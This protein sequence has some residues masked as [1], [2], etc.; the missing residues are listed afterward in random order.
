MNSKFYIGR[1]LYGGER[2][3]N[4]VEALDNSKYIVILAEPGAGKTRLLES[5]AGRLNVQKNSANAFLHRPVTDRNVPVVIDGFDELAKI[6]SSGIHR[7]LG[8]ACELRPSKLVISSRS[9]EWD[10]SYTK[11]FDDYFECKPV[12]LRIYPFGQD[13]QQQLFENYLINESFADFKLQVSRFDLEPLLP[14]PQFLKL[15]ADAYIESNRN[16]INKKSI[17]SLAVDRLAKESNTSINAR[18]NLPLDKKVELTE[19]IFAK[20]LLSGA[21]GVNSSDV[22]AD[23]VFPYI[24]SLFT[25]EQNLE[26]LLSSKLFLFGE[27][28]NQHYPVHKIVMEYCAANYLVRKISAATSFLSLSQSLAII[29][30]N[31]VVRDELRGL[32][33]WMAALGNK[34]IQ[35][36]LVDLDPYAVLANGDPSQLL[37]SSKKRLLQ[38]LKKVADENPHF[39]RSDMW[40]TFSVAGFFTVDFIEDLRVVL[41]NEINEGHL[42]GLIL[43]LLENSQVISLLL[44][45]LEQF[46]IAEDVDKNIRLLAIQRLFECQNFD[47]KAILDILISN[48]T[49]TSL[50]IAEF[51]IE[52]VGESF[53]GEFYIRDFL[54]KCSHLYPAHNAKWKENLGERYFIRKIISR[55]DL[56]LTEFLLNNFSKDIQCI[57]GKEKYEC[58]C[59]T[60]ISKVVGLLLDRYFEVTKHPYSSLKI[61][62]WIRNL[63]FHKVKDDESSISVK[64]IQENDDLRQGII[65]QI[66]TEAVDEDSVDRACEIFF[67]SHNHSGLR[68]KSEDYFF[69]VDMAFELGNVV[70][71]SRFLPIHQ[72]YNN[73][74]Q[75]GSLRKYMKLQARNDRDFLWVWIKRNECNKNNFINNGKYRYS[76]LRRR[77]AR[78]VRQREKV[79]M[80]NLEF[81]KVNR[82]LIESG[83]H[84]SS[85]IDFSHLLLFNL[86]D[87]EDKYEYKQIARIALKNCLDFIEPYVPNLEELVRLQFESKSKASEQVLY[88]ACLEIYREKSSLN[89]IKTNILQS[90]RTNLHV[91]YDGVTDEERQALRNEVDRII[92]PTIQHAE[93]FLRNYIEPQLSVAGFG[94][95]EIDWLKYD[96]VFKPLQCSLSLEWLSKYPEISLNTADTLFDL[97]LQHGERDILE[98]IIL[99]RCDFY[100]NLLHKHKTLPDAFKEKAQFWFFRGFI[101]LCDV[102]AEA[103][104]N[105]LEMD[106][107]SIFLFSDNVDNL[108]YGASSIWPILSP[109]KVW[110]I[111]NGFI[112]KWPKVYL[113]S[114]WGTGDPENEI[115]YRFLT[116]IFWVLDKNISNDSISIL[117][118]LI[119]DNRFRDF[120]LNLKSIRASILRKIALTNFEAPS[121]QK[122]VSLLD[123]NEV[124]TVEGL[125]ALLLEELELYQKDLNG[126][127]TT[128]KEIFYNFKAKDE[129][130]RLGEVDATL[131]I[132]DRL[133]LR[134]EPKGFIITPEHQM[135]HANRCDITCAKLIDNKKRLLV[136]EAKGQWH[137]DLYTAATEQLS[138]RYAIHPDA[139]QQGI[140]LVLWF[141]EKYERKIANLVNM[142]IKTAQQLK[143][144]IEQTIPT[145]LKGLIDVF[146]LD[147]C[148]TD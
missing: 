40:R 4:E 20:L 57:C 29:A 19:E 110:M 113:P 56:A 67:G 87:V 27:K 48:A 81:L 12:L 73:K 42:L 13:E 46:V 71:W 26:T 88:A 104:F 52:K 125:R 25:T 1:K 70:L 93:S 98:D 94:C 102:E 5:F 72:F 97:A 134:L 143:E 137:K 80:E 118:K 108:R 43:E 35:E 90:L 78:V 100:G 132:A 89:E 135:Q 32:L 14:N 47:H 28:E 126:S 146:V 96:N 115:A 105:F 92:F 7:L 83:R 138:K 50:S 111:L 144:S 62:Q 86:K 124:A 17:F 61:W 119:A 106:K 116:E 58:D 147:L 37:P 23:R 127:E 79:R 44:N 84:L 68:L 123:K 75:D 10:E 6:D 66:F 15:F 11:A 120:E 45:E 121:P 2:S 49:N 31:S 82:T 33:G 129:V 53:F 74:K 139:E 77:G 109:K 85:L 117:N 18:N 55:L 24:R 145:E 3:Y 148:K 54:K 103:Y 112:D 63:N 141:G 107:N 140:Y 69:I 91:Y 114:A 21:E 101:F 22:G 133:R 59:V 9:S 36:A 30:P 95:T 142:T 128:T 122:I 131:R 65:R 99:K 16:F 136:I 34:P 39:R 41:L 8:K 60:G 51:I 38:N 130:E 76:Y 64:I